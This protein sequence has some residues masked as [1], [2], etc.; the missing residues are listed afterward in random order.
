MRDEFCA[1]SGS[2]GASNA[3]AASAFRAMTALMAMLEQAIGHG[4]RWECETTPDMKDGRDTGGRIIRITIE[5][6]DPET[7]P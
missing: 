5:A 1:I 7:P 2:E 3:S 4:Q 6:P